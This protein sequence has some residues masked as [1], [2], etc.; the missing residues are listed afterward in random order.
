[1][2]GLEPALV[3]VLIAELAVEALDEAVLHRAP[4]LDQDVAVLIST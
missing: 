3:Q 4:R 2:Q 1:V